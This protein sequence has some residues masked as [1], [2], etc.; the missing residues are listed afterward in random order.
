MR[1][2]V[3]A[4]GGPIATSRG[5][6]IHLILTLLRAFEDAFA[7]ATDGGR[8][9]AMPSCR[10]RL[11]TTSFVVGMLEGP[12]VEATDGGHDGNIRVHET[13]GKQEP[14]AGQCLSLCVS[15]QL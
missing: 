14:Q 6:M 4:L 12:V 2:E 13:Q 8:G 3:D 1:K 9:G 5:G 7:K 10:F 15:Q 11:S